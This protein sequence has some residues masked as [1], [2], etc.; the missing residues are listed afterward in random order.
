VFKILFISMKNIKIS[1]GT[2]TMLKEYC[3][4]KSL[5]ISNWV[6]GVLNYIVTNNT[7]NEKEKECPNIQPKNL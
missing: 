3:K 2:H 5:K 1:D 6:D 7:K 4:Q